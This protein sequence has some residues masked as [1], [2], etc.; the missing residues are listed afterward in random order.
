M[1]LYTH[2]SVSPS[3]LLLVEMWGFRVFTTINKDR[4]ST[5][6]QNFCGQG[7]HLSVLIATDKM[8]SLV[9]VPGRA[10]SYQQWLRGS[11]RHPI[12]LRLW[13]I[14]LLGFSCSH[15]LEV[16]SLWDLDFHFSSGCW[17]P[18]F[19]WVLTGHLYNSSLGSVGS[20]GLHSFYT[21]DGQSS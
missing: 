7:F 20:N 15:E 11:S 12:F 8:F 17:C 21:L 18:T 13:D 3:I 1:S 19:F 5:T 16:A 6:A 14:H 2:T 4:V 10:H 9:V